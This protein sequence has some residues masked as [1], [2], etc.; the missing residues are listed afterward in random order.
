MARS[1]T[2]NH[3]FSIRCLALCSTAAGITS[4]ALLAQELSSPTLRTSFCSDFAKPK[5]CEGLGHVV[6][7]LCIPRLQDKSMREVT[8][9]ITFCLIPSS[10]WARDI[11]VLK[12]LLILQAWMCLKW[13]KGPLLNTGIY[14][15]L[16]SV[17]KFQKVLGF[18]GFYCVVFFKIYF[19]KTKN[20]T[21]STRYSTDV[22]ILP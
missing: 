22:T 16:I 14:K 17:T 1:S 9:G 12:D 15:S 11:F 19:P 10:Q 2:R 6:R 20:P 7:M 5:V 21:D 3:L 8:E 18:F 13:C 4:T